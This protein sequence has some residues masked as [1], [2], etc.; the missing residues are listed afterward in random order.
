MYYPYELSSVT[1]LNEVI[2]VFKI[3]HSNDELVN[4]ALLRELMLLALS[5]QEA[6]LNIHSEHTLFRWLYNE[7]R[8]PKTGFFTELFLQ[9]FETI[10]QKYCNDGWPNEHKQQSSLRR[11]VNQ[12]LKSQSLGEDREWSLLALEYLKAV[13]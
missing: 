10:E 11:E 12:F 2:S 5:V 3:R 13:K 7:V 1:E 9:R 4:F 8:T 6:K